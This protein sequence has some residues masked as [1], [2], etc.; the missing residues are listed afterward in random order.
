MLRRAG[1]GLL[2]ETVWTMKMVEDVKK[3][4]KSMRIT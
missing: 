2:V 3:F 1:S 4:H